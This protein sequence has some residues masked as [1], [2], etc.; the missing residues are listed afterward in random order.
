MRFPR[1]VHNRLSY[2]GAIIATLALMVFG[3]LVILHT[4]AG[5]ARAPY[6]GLLIFIAVP[7]VML[8]GLLLI[9]IGMLFEWR[10]LR[11]TGKGSIQRFPVVDLNDP[12]YRNAVAVFAGGSVFLLFVS[13]FGSYQAYEST[14]S[15]AFCGKLCHTVMAPEYTTYEHSPHARVRC[16]DCHVGPGAD[17]YVKSKISGLY[18]VYAVLFDKFP[19]PIPAPISSLRPA[20]QTCEQCHW[21]EQFFGGQQKQQVHFLPDETNTRW[22]INLLIKTGGGSPATGQTEGIHWH[23]NLANR[24]E[25]IAMD[26]QRQHIPWVRMVNVATGE[27]TEYSSPG[28]SKAALAGNHIRTMDCMDCHDRPT[29]IF[30]SP[31]EAVNLALETGKIDAT[32][33][34]IKRTGVQLLAATYPS[35]AAALAGIAGGMTSFYRDKYPD[36]LQTRP[37]AVARAVAAL[38]EIYRENFFP[39][40]KARWNVYPD[41]I[42][43]LMFSGCYRCHDGQHTSADG[44]TITKDCTACHSIL[45][46]GRPPQLAFSSE[47]RG[48]AFQHPEDIGDL[49]QEMPCNDCHTGAAP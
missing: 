39:Q 36:V 49:W 4:V 10:H 2:G 24:I 45:A 9:P 35:T 40:M 14:E 3:F 13:V 47:P 11:R 1:L 12:A 41:N 34:F 23:M 25:Y 6:A 37:D 38:Q 32:L 46:Q 18:Q 33:P 20:R 27:V 43:H 26:T 15:V 16:V 30:R 22:E 28:A 7:A 48:V 17:W 5:A 31:S 8:C 21:P 42:G 19:R 44:K 29:H